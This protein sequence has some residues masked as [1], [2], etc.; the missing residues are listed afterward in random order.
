MRA[1]RPRGE[2]NAD[3]ILKQVQHKGAQH[4][5]SIMSQQPTCAAPNC[6]KPATGEMVDATTKQFVA[7]VCSQACGVAL[8]GMPKRAADDDDDSADKRSAAQREDPRELFKKQMRYSHALATCYDI[9]SKLNDAIDAPSVENRRRPNPNMLNATA[10]TLTIGSQ[11]ASAQ[12]AQNRLNELMDKLIS[13][14]G[15]MR[16][17]QSYVDVN[18]DE[19][20]Q[21]IR[22][23]LADEIT[24]DTFDIITNRYLLDPR[25]V[26][27]PVVDDVRLLMAKR[28]NPVQLLANKSFFGRLLFDP[29]RVS[30]RHGGP[31]NL[32]HIVFNIFNNP[33]IFDQSFAQNDRVRYDYT[34]MTYQQ[35]SRMKIAYADRFR[36][37]EDRSTDEWEITD[38]KTVK[39]N[40]DTGKLSVAAR[41]ALMLTAKW[42]VGK[43][44]ICGFYSEGAKTRVVVFNARDD[45]I[46]ESSFVIDGQIFDA[47]I[48]SDGLIWTSRVISDRVTVYSQT[49]AEVGTIS[50]NNPGA[51]VALYWADREG[52]W[53]LACRRTE[54]AVSHEKYALEEAARAR[55]AP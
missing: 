35:S 25:T 28:A 8:I 45:R 49:G 53:L 23:G 43:R 21:T 24:L 38:T 42:K 1:S 26:S 31:A 34:G 54:S 22:T 10:M 11:V 32:Q 14:L 37:R 39:Y 3:N 50:M 48:D 15:N 18:I 41:S 7:H 52:V 40:G 16:A 20:I 19:A 17:G 13:A 51:S 36:Y 12:T 30:F 33:R 2:I 44:I 47:A 27:K 9:Y 6:A 46:D 55:V 29:D 4:L 5:P